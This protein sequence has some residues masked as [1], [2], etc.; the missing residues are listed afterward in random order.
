MV[1][2]IAEVSTAALLVKVPSEYVNFSTELDGVSGLVVTPEVAPSTGCFFDVT[3]TEDASMLDNWV[4]EELVYSSGANE[5]L[6]MDDTL[7]I[8]EVV[9]ATVFAGEILAVV[10]L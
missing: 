9:V 4:T 6:L 7:I 10:E 8:P 5:L 2:P 3:G 1:L